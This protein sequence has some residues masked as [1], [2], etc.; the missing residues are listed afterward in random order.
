M[1]RRKLTKSI[2]LFCLV[3]LLC[4]SIAPVSA[5]QSTPTTSDQTFE[6]ALAKARAECKTL[7][8]NPVFDRLRDKVPFGQQPTPL[9]FTNNE[10]L[11]RKDRAVLDLVAATNQQCRTAYAPLHA[12]LPP[13]VTAAIH[14]LERKEDALIREL[15]VGRITFGGYNVKIDGV[16]K[17]YYFVVRSGNVIAR[18]QTSQT[19]TNSETV[20][21]DHVV[22]LQELQEK[23]FNQET[24]A[25]LDQVSKQN[26]G[27]AQQGENPVELRK[28]ANDLKAAGRY[29][30]ATPYARRAL[31]IEEHRSGP[32]H[33]D[34]ALSLNNLAELYRNQ[35]RYADAEP[36]IKRSLAIFEKALGPDHPDVALSL[37]NLAS[38]HYNQGRYSDAEPFFKRSLA[39]FEKALGPDH[40][41]VATLLNNLALLYTN[42][43][44]YADAEPLH[45]RSLAIREKA[46][47]PDHL[48]V[49]ISLNN[50]AALYD[51]QGRYADAEPLYRRSLA[52]REKALGPDHPDVAQSLSNLALLRARQGHYADAEPLYRRSLAINEKALG[53][54]H[55]DVAISLNNLAALYR[56]QGRYAD[57][58][59]L[60]R[61]S[62][63]IC[64]KALGPDHPDVAISLN[65]LAELY[66]NQ[67][68]YVDAEPLHQALT[69]DTGKSAWSR[70]SRRRDNR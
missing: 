67:G 13:Q 48:D 70:S 62:L 12:M 29:A 38:L 30:E 63:A 55:P 17:E 11:L 41:D 8:S 57:A 7:W 23:Y 61:R 65:N 43:G 25:F 2:I 32:D 58:E 15:Y 49:A 20:G 52:I 53:P 1:Q 40:P 34:V 36:F 64:E 10:R 26:T 16:N 33:P 50:L 51:N 24:K 4:G 22:T 21:E 14:D 3:V 59:P 27:Q 54:D 56:N 28:K 46:L 6:S 5:E 39:I 69:G 60:Y 47:G 68:R 31:D 42:Q 9:M 45:R 37:N 19:N 44:R 35:G 18:K 66:R